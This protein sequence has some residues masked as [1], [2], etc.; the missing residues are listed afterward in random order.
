M[1]ERRPVPYRCAALPQHSHRMVERVRDG[2]GG[3]GVSLEQLGV[4]RLRD[5]GTVFITHG[6]VGGYSEW[7]VIG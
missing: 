1:N 7:L 5:D 6:P 2:V 3:D 4:K